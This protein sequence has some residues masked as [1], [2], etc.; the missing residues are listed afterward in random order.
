MRRFE[1]RSRGEAEVAQEHIEPAGDVHVA[2][3]FGL[4]GQIAELAP[5]AAHRFLAGNAFGLEL[6]GALG[7]VEGE[8]ALD[9]ALQASAGENVANS[10]IPG[11][12]EVPRR[13]A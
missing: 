7:E 8:F 6:I 11:H 9:L 2:C 4:R 12:I 5:R 1:Q 3:P 10:S 13:S